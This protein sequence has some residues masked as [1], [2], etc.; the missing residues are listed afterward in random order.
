M[1]YFKTTT[2]I[3]TLAVIVLFN[4]C[5]SRQTD[6]YYKYDVYYLDCA[7]THFNDSQDSV[8]CYNPVFNMNLTKYTYIDRLEYWF[9]ILYELKREDLKGIF[10][11]DT[12][13]L[14][15]YDSLELYAYKK[16]NNPR[17]EDRIFDDPILR[18]LADRQHFPFLKVEDYNSITSEYQFLF[19]EIGDSCIKITQAGGDSKFIDTMCIK[20]MYGLKELNLSKA[21]NNII[22]VKDN[23]RMFR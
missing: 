7:I 21:I 23:D 17:D 6:K 18:T 22:L 16:Y 15:L 3:L 1:Q 10:F 4:S 19:E 8:K 5:S 11:K 12:M 9:H 14:Y 20:E 13:K 2:C